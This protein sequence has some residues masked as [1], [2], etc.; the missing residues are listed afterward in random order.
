V[1]YNDEWDKVPKPPGRVERILTASADMREM[2]GGFVTRAALEAILGPE[3]YKLTFELLDCIDINARDIRRR[4]KGPKPSCTT[5]L[6]NVGSGCLPIQRFP[7]D[8]GYGMPPP[9]CQGYAPK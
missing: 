5:C 3:N 8:A 9:Y 1:S 6:H 4:K 2:L 7:H